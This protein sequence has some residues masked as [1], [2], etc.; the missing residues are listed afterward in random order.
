MCKCKL[1]GLQNGLNYEV[2]SVDVRRVVFKTGCFQIM[3]IRVV[4][5][6]HVTGRYRFE[7]IYCL[8]R[9]GSSDF[10]PVADDTMFFRNVRSHYATTW[11]KSP[12]DHSLIR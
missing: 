7:E 4:T 6:C 11:H 3:V 1:L 9:H 12:Q 5:P 2:R 10:N 8:H